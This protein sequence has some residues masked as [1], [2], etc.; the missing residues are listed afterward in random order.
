LADQIR[1]AF[2]ALVLMED[3]RT[4]PQKEVEVSVRASARKRFVR[5]IGRV[6]WEPSMRPSRSRS[7]GAARSAG[8]SHAQR[9]LSSVKRAVGNALAKAGRMD[10]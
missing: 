9:T 5:E 6:V 10:D 4:S 3:V 8:A 7:A 1:E 2:S